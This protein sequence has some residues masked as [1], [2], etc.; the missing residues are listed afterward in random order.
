MVQNLQLRSRKVQIAWYANHV[1]PTWTAEGCLWS[2]GVV[3]IHSNFY[4]RKMG[5]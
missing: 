4:G 5:L 3:D 2:L 1:I